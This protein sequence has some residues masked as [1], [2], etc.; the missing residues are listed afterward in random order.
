M[1]SLENNN[2]NCIVVGCRKIFE[3][4][5]PEAVA[6]SLNELSLLADTLGLK[7]VGSTVLNLRKINPSIFYGKGQ[8]ESISKKAATMECPYIIFNDEVYYFKL[9]LSKFN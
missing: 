8:I 1:S 4:Q 2:F 7:V 9:L 5:N 3:D 6:S